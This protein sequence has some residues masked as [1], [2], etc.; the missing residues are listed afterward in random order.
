[1]RAYIQ[2]PSV[3]KK[4]FGK[5]GWRTFMLSR[6]SDVQISDETFDSKRPQYKEGNDNSMSV[7]YVTSDW[8]K[9]PK[10]KKDKKPT[11]PTPKPEKPTT[12]V[13]KPEVKPQELPQP[14]PEEKPTS[15]QTEPTEPQQV[16]PEKEELPQPKPEE[17]PSKTPEEDEE[18]KNLQESVNKI[19]RLMFL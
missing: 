7:T 19:K 10:V 13:V 14:K 11:E 18:E 17:R 1:M 5:T 15:P 6:M 9:Q 3:S 2:P 4:G 12:T 8:T 16:E